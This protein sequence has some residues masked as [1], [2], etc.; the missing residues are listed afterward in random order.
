[1]SELL[2]Y[3]IGTSSYLFDEEGLMKTATKSNLTKELEKHLPE[4]SLRTLPA[5]PV[6][7]GNI[8]EV[9]ANLKKI[10]ANAKEVK[11]FVKFVH[12]FLTFVKNAASG[13]SR[14]D[15]VFDS[16]IERTIKDSVRQKRANTPAIELNKI[17]RTKPLP[18]QMDT[19]WPSAKNKAHLERLI[20]EDAMLYPLNECTSNLLVSAFD[21]TDGDSLLSFNL[22][23]GLVT[24]VPDLDRK[25]E[26][27]DL[28]MILHALHTAESG[29]K[30]FII[31]SQDTDV[32]VLCLYNWMRFESCGIGELWITAS[33]GDSSRFIPVQAIA[34]I[35]EESTC[36]VLPAV[37][38]LT[39]F[40]YI[41]KVGAKLAALKAKPKFAKHF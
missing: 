23:E 29:I 39:G 37:H 24:P 8:V 14:I 27:A 26:E 38:T 20:H 32:L 2:Q 4:E 17:E 1:M 12:N 11:T 9:M 15:L 41:S 21:Q 33:I 35:L 25:I 18:K 16:Y 10:R 6:R 3:A 19:F 36:S 40:D 7:T 31:V 28:K 5:T 30:R 13:A 22:A 34:V